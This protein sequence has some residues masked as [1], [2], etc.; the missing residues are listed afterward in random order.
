MNPSNSNMHSHIVREDEYRAGA[1]RR[2]AGRMFQKD[3]TPAQR[4]LGLIALLG[5][6]AVAVVVLFVFF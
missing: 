5:V 6:I 4:K 1:S 2:R 3:L